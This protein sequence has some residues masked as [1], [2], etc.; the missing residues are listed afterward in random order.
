MAQPVSSASSHS[1]HF[2]KPVIR[3]WELF[4]KAIAEVAFE[5]LLPFVV[6]LML[7]SVL[8]VTLSAVVVPMAALGLSFSAAFLF[9]GGGGAFPTA[10]VITLPEIPL[11]SL[12]DLPR[13]SQSSA[14][15]PV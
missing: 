14:N 7:Y 6:C 10:P 2:S 15:L 4:A 12:R 1:S 9:L 5:I 8:P 3:N 13:S 11:K